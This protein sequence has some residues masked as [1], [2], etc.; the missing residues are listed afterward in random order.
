MTRQKL[1]AT[2]KSA[3]QDP[4]IRRALLLTLPLLV[5][6]LSVLARFLEGVERRPG[7]VV[8]DPV[9]ILFTPHDV[10]WVTF[11]L[12]YAGLFGAIAI[13]MRDPRRL[14]LAIHTYMIMVVF[15]ICAMSLLPLEPPL[16]MIP[17]T[18][19]FVEYFGTGIPLN[20]DLFFSGHTSTLFLLG[21]TMPSR[22]W[23]TVFFLCAAA[24]AC[25]VLLQ[26]IHYTVDVFVA[27]FVAY[28]SYRLALSIHSR[29]I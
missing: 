27:P 23:Q 12:I 16:S 7:V 9:L 29:L 2:W 21:L 13:L 15:R 11:L 26:H 14:L 20:K 5:I 4:A 10:T 1:A 22:R 28:A 25:C 24:V 8:P 19:P 3:W 6:T 18:D 17:L